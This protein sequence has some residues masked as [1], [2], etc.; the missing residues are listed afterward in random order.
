MPWPRRSRERGATSP[1][2][3][4]GPQAPSG[5]QNESKFT[6]RGE[7]GS[8]ISYS[9]VACLQPRRRGVSVVIACL[10]HLAHRPCP[11]PVSR[12]FVLISFSDFLRTCFYSLGHFF[13]KYTCTHETRLIHS[14]DT[15][16]STTTVVLVRSIISTRLLCLS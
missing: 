14:G 10:G 5:A 12:S 11:R 13:K 3:S 16:L 2:C 4:H 1:A 9:T 6:E 7:M 8:I 15:A